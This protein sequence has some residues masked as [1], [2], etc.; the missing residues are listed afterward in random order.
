[1]SDIRA[2]IAGIEHSIDADLRNLVR[3]GTQEQAEQAARTRETLR[4]AAL[5]QAL[6]SLESRNATILELVSSLQAITDGLKRHPV[7]DALQHFREALSEGQLLLDDIQERHGAEANPAV[8]SRRTAPADAGPIPATDPTPSLSL[9]LSPPPV[10]APEAEV[11]IAPS[12]PPVDEP[13][14]LTSRPAVPRTATVLKLSPGNEAFREAI[15]EAS[16]R[17][18][19]APSALAALIDAEAAK[20]PDGS[21]DPK[22]ANPRSSARG[23]TPFLSATWIDMAERNGTFLNELARS[24]GCLDSRGKVLPARRN[25]LLDLRLDA[26]IS[27]LTAADFAKRN[28]EF[29]A[30]A[31]CI[32]ANASHDEKARIAYLAHHEGPAGARDFILGSL[33]EDRAEK[34]LRVNAGSRAASLRAVHGSWRAAYTVFLNEYMD[35][36]IQPSRFRT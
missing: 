16:R 9:A 10:V 21:W 3:F 6:A 4:L 27:I 33:A 36:K 14:P 12:T 28:L 8:T 22:S 30:V 29:L 13:P 19:L 5:D 15:L 17:C 1:M 11:G 7:G 20:R 24:R 31:G 34:L 23:L 32:P 35:R 26:S 2:K 25:E 18:G